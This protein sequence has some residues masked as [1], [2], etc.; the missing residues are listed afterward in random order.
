MALRHDVPEMLLLISSSSFD[1]ADQEPRCMNPPNGGGPVV[2]LGSAYVVNGF[3]FPAE[4]PGG[5]FE[6][7]IAAT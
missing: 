7:S 6:K 1:D 5:G 3:E 2:V 4:K